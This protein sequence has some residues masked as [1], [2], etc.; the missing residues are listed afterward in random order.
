VVKLTESTPQMVRIPAG[1]FLMGTSERQIDQF[2]QHSDTARTWQEKGY[3]A[4]EQPQH[5]VTL[6]DYSI[7]KYP[8][9]VGEYLPFVDKTGYLDRRHW[10]EAGWE[11][12]DEGGVVKPALW[13]DKRWTSDERLPVVG[14]SWYEAYAYCRWLSEVTGRDYRLPTEAEWE[15][16]ARGADGR[17]YPWGDVFDAARCNTR[18]SGL[19]RT[20]VVGQY[21]PGGDS[22][23][24]CAEMVGNVSEWTLSQYRSY[25]HDADD[26]RD[27][28]AG[29]A[30]R[31][32]RGGSWHSP[33][34]RARAA[35]RGYN[36]PFFADD[37]LG[38]RYALSE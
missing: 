3:F 11:W 14:V 17:L 24:G 7:G 27:D 4:R 12:R 22:P 16:A 2:A 31:V 28:P 13:D 21:S 8:V 32:T 30:E 34:I 18:V 35:A 25:P 37:D 19:E 5:T 15:K 20:T 9:T 6:P 36:D 10:T 38:F 1:R 33:A 26:G 23:Y 29:E